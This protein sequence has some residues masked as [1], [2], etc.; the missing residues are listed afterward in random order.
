MIYVLLWHL[1]TVGLIKLNGKILYTPSTEGTMYDMVHHCIIDGTITRFV[2][3]EKRKVIFKCY[4]TV[5]YVSFIKKHITYYIKL[6]L[7]AR[8]NSKNIY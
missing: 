1:I 5:F 8:K 7:R 4:H 3:K 2:Q 6:N